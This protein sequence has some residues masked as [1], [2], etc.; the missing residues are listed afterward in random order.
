MVRLTSQMSSVVG[1][2]FADWHAVGTDFL[3]TLECHLFVKI[4]QPT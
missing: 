2:K 4:L 1:C 3:S